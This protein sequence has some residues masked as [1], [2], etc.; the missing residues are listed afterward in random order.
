M[1]NRIHILGPPGSGKSFV[2]ELLSSKLDIPVLSLDNV[3]AEDTAILYDVDTP[4][5]ERQEKLST[6]VD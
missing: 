4:S 6:I 3:C 5:T 2:A 1:T